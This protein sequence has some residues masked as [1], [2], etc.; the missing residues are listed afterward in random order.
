MIIYKDRIDIFSRFCD[1]RGKDSINASGF[2]LQRFYIIFFLIKQLKWKTTEVKHCI[3]NKLIRD[4][5]KV[6]KSLYSIFTSLIIHLGKYI[7][8]TTRYI[9]VNM[10]LFYLSFLHE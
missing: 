4:V 5:A 3:S 6:N 9:S 8:A 10:C 1:Q 7:I 2:L